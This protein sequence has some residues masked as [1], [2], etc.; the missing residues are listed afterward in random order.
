[1]QTGF[2]CLINSCTVQAFKFLVPKI[3]TGMPCLVAVQGTDG[4]EQRAG[5][6]VSGNKNIFLSGKSIS[7]LLH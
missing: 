1:M 2:I 3:I 5:A 7:I 4:K 6:E